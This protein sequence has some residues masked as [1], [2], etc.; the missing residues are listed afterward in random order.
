MELTLKERQKLTAITARKY[1]IA[2]KNEKTKI[3]G[4]FQEQTG[5]NRKYAIHILANEGKTIYAGKKVKLK[6]SHKNTK[7]RVYPV[8]YGKEVLDAL[9]LI[10]E[11]FNY[12]C[13]KLLAPFLRSNINGIVSE[14]TFTF[15]EE[16]IAKLGKISPST[17][18]RLLKSSKAKLK[19]KGTSGTK[20]A[21]K[22]IK[23]LI[24]TLSH[25]QCT[26]QGGGLWQI[27]L[28][29]HDGGNP[30]GE[31]CFTLTITEVKTPGQSTT[32]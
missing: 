11:A 10:W 32:H 16:V 17:I 14:P 5:Y 23:A 30:S 13:G 4:I 9:V 25:F 27:D 20:S 24:P 12:Q 7:K 8:T 22:H 15:S 3:L 18:D 19:I 28:V 2:K 26:E 21:A 6:V 29:Q 31:F 1:R